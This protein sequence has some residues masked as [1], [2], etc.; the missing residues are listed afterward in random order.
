MAAV[1]VCNTTMAQNKNDKQLEIDF[2]K[3]LSEQYKSNETGA[4]ALVARKGKIIYKKAF[5]MAN[6]ELNIS[7]QLDNVFRIGSITKQFTAVAILQLM[8]QGKLNLQDEIVK[9]IPDYPTHGYKITIEHLLTHTS[10]IKSYTGMKDYMDRMT[11]D[12]LPSEMI[13]HFKNEPME[14]APGTRWNYS[15]SGYFLLGYII[16]KVSGK[17]YGEYIEENIFKPIGMTNSLYGSNTKIIKNRVSGYDMGKNGYENA[18]PLS[19]TQP[20]AAGSILSTVEDMFKWNQALHAYKLVKKESLDKAFTNYALTDGTKTDY[21][22]GWTF[23]NIQESPS[24]EHGGGI[25]GS[26]TMAI[27]LPGEDVYVVVFSNCQCKHSGDVAIKM[28]GIAIGKPYAYKEISVE[29]SILQSYTGVYENARGELRVISI[30]ENKLYSKRGRNA[31]LHIRPYEKDNFYFDDAMV[32]IEFVRNSKGE[33]PSLILKSRNGNEEWTRTDKPIPVITEI[34]LSSAVLDMYVG[35]YEINPE[36]TFVITKEDDK[37]FLQA[38]GQEK[39]EIFAEA[40]TTFFLKVNDARL[41]FVKDDS[42]K[43]IKSILEQGG[44]RTDARKIK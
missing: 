34:K 25:N 23:A 26:S 13:D 5:G 12:L 11:L 7:M 41:E 35:E 6:L 15:N 36:F 43:V 2:D 44:R 29:N 18:Q 21:G 30:E 24:I 3:I 37:L 4:T 8:E 20:Y 10:G 19:M 40:E 38:T 31:K 42:G 27:Y 39:L 16:Q 9:F 14:F 28:A 1:L 33:V 22:Y 17:T 32:R